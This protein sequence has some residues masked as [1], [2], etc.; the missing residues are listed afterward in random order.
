[1]LVLIR[2]KVTIDFFIVNEKKTIIFKIAE[3]IILN[4]NLSY[5]SM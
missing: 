2:Y 3:Y 1:M 4:K 5:V